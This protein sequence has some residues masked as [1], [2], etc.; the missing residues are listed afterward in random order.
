MNEFET[1]KHEMPGAL[2]MANSRQTIVCEYNPHW[3]SLLRVASGRT[4]C[5]L[6]LCKRKRVDKLGSAQLPD[7]LFY[8]VYD[9]TTVRP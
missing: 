2:W 5:V 7:K 8:K 6:G 4:S 9:V 1:P 3:Q